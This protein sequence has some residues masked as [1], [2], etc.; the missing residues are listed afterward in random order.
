MVQAG[1]NYKHR[2]KK[3]KAKIIWR[4]R[5]DRVRGQQTTKEIPKK[6]QKKAWEIIVEVAEK[7]IK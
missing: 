5:E 1:L 7:K 6:R 3:K 4:K 2:T